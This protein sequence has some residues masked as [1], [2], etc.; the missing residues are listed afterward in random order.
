MKIAFQASLISALIL[1][2]L[3]ETAA[4][5]QPAPTS[6]GTEPNSSLSE[7]M[8]IDERELEQAIR[9][10]ESQGANRV[11]WAI[12]PAPGSNQPSHPTSSP[13]A[14]IPTEIAA[15][16]TGDASGVPH[17]S[18]GVGYDERASMEAVKSQYNLRL[19]FAISGSGDYLSGVK[20]R[21]QDAR[22]A[23]LLNTRSNGPWFYAQLPPGAYVLTLDHKGQ[24]QT[25]NVKIQPQGATVEN[26]YWT[27]PVSSLPDAG[28]G[29]WAIQAPAVPTLQPLVSSSGIPYL[30]GGGDPQQKARLEANQGPYNLRLHFKMDGTDTKAISIGVR[31]QDA[32]S[33]RTLMEAEA[34]GPLFFAKIPGG[35]YLVTINYAGQQH[36]RTLTVPGSGAATATFEWSH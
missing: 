25:R 3:G 15:A 10:G 17:V 11:E 26:L 9:E 22:G 29:D 34:T 35:K 27:G 8:P 13:P 19:L 12:A 2:G 33:Q 31:V 1:V 18:G 4:N 23:T 32:Y 36:Q 16:P 28:T 14:S 30:S 5:A 21:I 6:T 20:V 24:I 7:P